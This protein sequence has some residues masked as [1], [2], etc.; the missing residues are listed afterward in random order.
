VG[1]QYVCTAGAVAGNDFATVDTTN[2]TLTL[3]NDATL[4]WQWKTQYLLQAS[5]A[6]GGSVDQP[7]QWGDAGSNL[8]V[9][10]SN[11]VYWYFTGWSGDTQDCALAGNVITAAMTWARTVVAHFAENVA[12][13]GTP[14]SWMEDHGLTNPSVAVAETNDSDGDGML[15]WQEYMADTDPTNQ[16]SMLSITGV[17]RDGNGIRVDWKGGEWA[18][19][20]VQTRRDLTATGELWTSIRTNANLPTPITNFVIDT[21]ATNSVLFYRVKAER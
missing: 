2:V 3:T 20:Y 11:A 16:A 19:Q 8:T 13:M 17:T 14:L 4:T 18:R 9:T 12:P 7:D 10:A 21:E 6:G 5:V 1:T 15:A